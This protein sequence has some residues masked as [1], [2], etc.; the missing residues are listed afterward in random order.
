MKIRELV[1]LIG[2]IF[3]FVAMITEKNAG[4]VILIVP[5]LW[6]YS[7]PFQFAFMVWKALKKYTNEA[8]A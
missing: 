2:I 5:I 7:L 8:K 3:L 4:G 6:L 1:L